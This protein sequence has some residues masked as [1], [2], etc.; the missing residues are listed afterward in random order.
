MRASPLR[1]KHALVTSGTTALGAAIARRLADAGAHVIIS[2]V[3]GPRGTILASEIG[4]GTRFIGLDATDLD[5]V[6]YLARQTTIDVLINVPAPMPATPTVDAEG[7][8]FD[9]AFDV[10]VRAPYFLVGAVAAC[11]IR[12]GGGAIVTI[13]GATPEMPSPDRSIGDAVDAALMSLTR[14]WAREFGPY[15]IRVEAL[16]IS[17]DPADD[18]ADELADAVYRVVTAHS[19]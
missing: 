2:D 1:G 5:A 4:G 6:D 10:N 3:D 7:P 17:P 19:A 12:Q 18:R 13:V 16:A 8:D 14:T 15:G 9:T 11:M